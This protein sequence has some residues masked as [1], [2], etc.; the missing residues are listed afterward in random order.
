MRLAALAALLLAA[1]ALAQVAADREV[2]LVRSLHE[3]GKYQEA[4]QRAL[5]SLGRPSFTDEQRLALH[6]L[7]GLSAFTLGDVRAASGHFL[8]VL[9]LDPDH[10]LDPFAV[11]PPAIRA[12]EQVRKDNAGPLARAREQI[13]VKLD[14]ERRAAAERERARTE[15]EERRRRLEQLSSTIT[16]RTVERRSLL[17][18]FVPFGA[19]QLQQGRVE[20]GV[21]FAIS[22]AV[23]A[24]TSIIS[25]FAINALYESD[26]ITFT[27]RLTADGTGRFTATVRR[28]PDSRQTSYRVWSTFKYAT[29]IGFYAAWAGGTIDALAHHQ[30]EVVTET[31]QPA[32]PPAAPAAQL[33]LVPTAGGLGA[34]LTITF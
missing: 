15:E 29:G 1:P 27:D 13:A 14:Q 22:E 7:A 18:A 31:Q 19:G 26:S 24:L 6:E 33:G 16:V 4:L 9:Q 8:Q 28:I 5:E 10:Q 11:A 17:L 2:E 12:F 32:P 34:G 25:Y 30:A 20:W 21:T 3:V 23:L